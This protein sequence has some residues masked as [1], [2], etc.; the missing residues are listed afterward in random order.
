MRPTGMGKKRRARATIGLCEGIS[1]SFMPIHTLQKS[2]K[3]IR[4]INKW[5]AIE[6]GMSPQIHNIPR[7]T[8]LFREIILEFD[9]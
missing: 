7:P 8:G 1:N 4:K 5:R 9:E 3:N 2:D 6:N